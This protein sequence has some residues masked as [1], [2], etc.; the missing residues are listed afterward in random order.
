MKRECGPG[1][2]TTAQVGVARAP[3]PRHGV[4]WYDDGRHAIVRSSDGRWWRVEDVPEFE[5]SL[6]D[7][8][9]PE[10]DVDEV[11]RWVLAQS[12]QR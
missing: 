7:R 12:E 1:L 11:D 6:R 4:W 3:T 9:N 8:A 10:V 2:L 5:R